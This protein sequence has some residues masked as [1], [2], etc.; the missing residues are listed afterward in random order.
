MQP[1]QIMFF[2]LPFFM[3]MGIAI[4]GISFYSFGLALP[5]IY[6]LSTR[7]K[8]LP[9][10]FLYL[11]LTLV[12]LHA[13]FPIFNFINLLF[14][15]KTVDPSIYQAPILWSKFLLSAFPSSFF[16]GGL[17]LILFYFISQKLFG[18]NTSAPAE[19]KDFNV[20][21][22]AFLLGLC[23]ASILFFGIVFYQHATGIDLRS[24][25]RSS[26]SYLSVNDM[27]SP[28][29]G[30]RI[31][32]FFG[33]PL[34]VAGVSLAYFTFVW[35]LLLAYF[36]QKKPALFSYLPFHNNKIYV[37]LILGS[38]AF[39]H[40]L[41]IVLSGGRTALAVAGILL[42]LIPLASYMNKGWARFAK[43][44]VVLIVMAIGVSLFAQ[45]FNLFKRIESVTTAITQS[46]TLEANNN[47]IYFWKTYA[48]MIEDKPWTGEGNYW[49]RN[50]VRDE[51]YNRLGYST[52]KEKFAAHNMYLEVL[53][54]L[55]IIGT[56]LLVWSMVKLYW[57]VRREI[58]VGNEEKS[59]LIAPGI[60]LLVAFF[61][62]AVHGLTQNV[63]FDSSVCYIYLE[64]LIVMVWSRVVLRNSRAEL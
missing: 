61:A 18:S 16:I 4:Q 10:F 58:A 5:A 47:R 25:F 37:T 23:P 17:T 40:L 50:G 12:F 1:L 28:A 13:L 60:A 46:Q 31:Y 27:F 22:R 11:G 15:D 8:P 36:S 9:P 30:F 33:H 24:I 52:L 42:F 59:I 44:S 7:K 38:T 14:P 26:I 20:P 39:V 62:N 51:Y 53:G 57:I 54:C 63:F 21:L 29:G 64:I 41:M 56:V 35:T 32:G 45:K 49:L 3:F 6:I 34:T 55:G 43:M 2:C 48:Q 19:S